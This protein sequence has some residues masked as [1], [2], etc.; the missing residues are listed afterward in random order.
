MQV[1]IQS[2]SL[3]LTHGLKAYTEKKLASVLSNSPNRI[4]QVAIRLSNIKKSRI[5]GDKNCQIKIK[6]ADT[7]EVV[8]NQT[9]QDVYDAINH[10]ANRAKNVM[11]RTLGRRRQFVNKYEALR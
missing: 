9:E 8:I 11:C 2:R 6:L 7:S 10:A 4:K 3:I 5:T 1:E